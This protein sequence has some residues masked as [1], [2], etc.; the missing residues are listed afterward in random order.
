MVTSIFLNIFD[1]D[2]SFSPRLVQNVPEFRY[3]ILKSQ[4]L[5]NFFCLLL[6]IEYFKK[7][8]NNYSRKFFRRK[9][10][11]GIQAVETDNLFKSS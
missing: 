1:Q 4:F 10:G 6:M 3:E 9:L 11:P 7:N 5:F 2:C 8:W